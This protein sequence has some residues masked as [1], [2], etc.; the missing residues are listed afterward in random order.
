MLRSQ[1]STPDLVFL[2]SSRFDGGLDPAEMTH[3]LANDLDRPDYRVVG[4]A[5]P[6]ADFLVMERVVEEMERAGRMPRRR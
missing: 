2:G 4:A 5:V 1:T 3:A 6:G